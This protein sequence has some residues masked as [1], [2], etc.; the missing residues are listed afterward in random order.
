MLYLAL[1][2]WGCNR[3]VDSTKSSDN[4]PD[5]SNPPPTDGPVIPNDSGTECLR[6]VVEVSPQDREN[7]VYYRTPVRVLLSSTDPTATV[8]VF[9]DAG[10]EV[11][12]ELVI[13]DVRLLWSWTDQPFQPLTHYTVRVTHQCAVEEVS[14]TTS[15]VGAPLLTDVT[16]NTYA[17][18]V[19]NGLWLQPIGAN[20]LFSTMLRRYRLVVRVNDMT[21]PSSLD[22]LAGVSLNDAQNP[23]APTVELWDMPFTDPYFALSSTTI[24]LVTDSFSLNLENFQLNGAFAPNGQYIQGAVVAGI[25]DTRSLGPA[26]GL[27]DTP[28]AVCQLVGTLNIACVACADGDP[29]CLDMLVEAVDAPLAPFDLQPVLEEDIGADCL[30]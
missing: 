28:Q 7:G 29:Y 19:A 26:L 11:P 22:V 18:D 1:A 2:M 4:G 30:P 20:G 10:V 15:E 14:W 12:G 17:L 5:G 23:C 21:D 24:A 8:Q 16:N 13:D 3:P 25:L 6:Q 27:A 9:D